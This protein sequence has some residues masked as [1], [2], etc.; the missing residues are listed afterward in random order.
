MIPRR[1]L[2][3]VP[4]Q[5]GRELVLYRRGD[6]FVIQV[7]DEEL[8]SSRAHGSEVALAELGLAALGERRS[9]RILVGGLG[10]GFTLRGVLDGLAKRP[11]AKVI[12]AELFP[13]VVAWNRDHFGHLAGRPLDDPR[14][15]VV[16]GDVRDR[17]TAGAG[18]DLA[19]LDVDNG[20]DAMTVETNQRLYSDRGIARL[21]AAL[22]PGGVAAFWSA[23]D[24]PHFAH[25]FHRGGFDVSVHRVSARPGGKGGRHVL[26]VGRNG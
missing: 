20:P 3:S 13:A 2:D 26:F 24:D 22:A 19:L 8:M 10:M 12:V 14:V 9:P 1:I 4:T 23:G 18:Y 5:D 15:Q 16:T 25:R 6:T 17:L 11:G 7:D 21:R